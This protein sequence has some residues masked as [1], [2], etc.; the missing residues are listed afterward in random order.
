MASHICRH[1]RRPIALLNSRH[2]R[3]RSERSSACKNRDLRRFADSAL[4]VRRIT[5]SQGAF[6]F[7]ALTAGN[8]R[9]EAK[10]ARYIDVNYGEK[11]LGAKGQVLQ[12]AGNQSLSLPAIKMAPQAVISGLLVDKDGDPVQGSRISLLQPRWKSGQLDTESV[13][14]TAADDQ[15]RY[16]F[17]RLSAG[18]YFLLATPARGSEGPG[19]VATNFL[20]QNGQAFRQVEGSTYYQDSPSFQGATPIRLRAGQELSGLAL[21]LSKTEARHVGGQ[22]PAEVLNTTPRVLYIS[23]E[24]NQGLPLLTNVP[25]QNDGSFLAEGL[26]PGRYL[27]RGPFVKEEIDLTRGDIDGLTIEPFDA[28]ELWITLHLD[29]APRSQMLSYPRSAPG[30]KNVRPQS[31]DGSRTDLGEQ[32]QGCCLTGAI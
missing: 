29:G 6:C 8:Y 32:I 30:P 23:A 7:E 9:V 13:Q 3:G 14:E 2:R 27:L 21:T 5:D 20:D 24:A 1:S 15:G 12:V 18:T 16:R 28:V 22:V 11:R 19:P 4:P 10:R 17:A 26:F 31:N 25:I